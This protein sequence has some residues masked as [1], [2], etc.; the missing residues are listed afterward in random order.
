MDINTLVNIILPIIVNFFF[1][2]ILAVVLSKKIDNYFAKLNNKKNYS[3]DIMMDTKHHLQKIKYH[4]IK[5]QCQMINDYDEG[6]KQFFYISGDFQVFFEDYKE[7]M[8]KYKQKHN[9]DLFCV[10]NLNE[11]INETR[12]AGLYMQQG[13]EKSELFAEALNTV[14]H[15]CQETISIYNSK[16]SEE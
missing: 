8:T 10:N 1:T 6:F 11:I 16:L 3:F 7:Y 4:I 12:K 5:L 14:L 9:N 2:S 15:L 13:A